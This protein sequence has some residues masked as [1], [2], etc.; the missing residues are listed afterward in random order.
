MKNL[1]IAIAAFISISFAHT[2]SANTFMKNTPPQYSGF[3]N[4][5]DLN[6]IK[7][8][9]TISFNPTKVT[10]EVSLSAAPGGNDNGTGNIAA[11]AK[12]IS[13]KGLSN[14][15]ERGIN[16]PGLKKGIQEKGLKFEVSPDGQRFLGGASEIVVTKG[17]VCPDGSVI[18]AGDRIVFNGSEY[19]IVSPR[20]AASGMATGK[21]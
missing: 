5:E 10:I 15:S 12:G 3:S 4:E 7:I 13:E 19:S 18:N 14:V 17:A 2:A 20:D 9:I 1:I 21:R 16:N 6:K 11:V 8:T